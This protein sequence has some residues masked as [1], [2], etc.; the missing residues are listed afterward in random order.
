VYRIGGGIY[1]AVASC[2]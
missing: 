1:A 2:L